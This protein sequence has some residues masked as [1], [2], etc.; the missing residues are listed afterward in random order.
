MRSKI[1][2]LLLLA[3]LAVY[4]QDYKTSIGLRGGWNSGIT[5]KHFIKESKALEI[6]FSTRLGYYRGYQITGL[7]E[8]HKAAFTASETEGF[9]WFYGF[10]AHFGTGY[11]YKVWKATGSWT[12]YYEDKVYSVFGI[13]GIFGLE[14][15]IPEI[16]LTVGVDVKPFIEFA[17]E[18]G[19]PLSIWDGALTVRFTL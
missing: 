10:G 8:I 18:Q 13:D 7:Y 15:K 4:S 14:Y 2:I 19:I 5:F 6:I 1:T 11:R 3:S 17:T 16:P 9:F 12:G